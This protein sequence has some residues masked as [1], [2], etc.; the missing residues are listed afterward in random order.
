[1]NAIRIYS[2]NAA[3][4]KFVVLKTNRNKRFRYHEFFVEGVRSINEAIRNNWHIVSLLYTTEKPLSGWAG[5]M[6]EQVA[7]DVNYELTARLMS[8]LSGKD[9]TSELMAVVRMRDDSTEP[10]RFSENPVIALFDRP[11]NKG[12]LGTVIRSCD[13][14]GVEELIITS[15]SVDLYDPDVIASAM[16]SFFRVPVVRASNNKQVTG[17][18]EAMKDRYPKF[19]VIGTTAH[20]QSP[21]DALDLTGPVLFMIG[22]ETEGLCQSLRDCCDVLATIPMS[23][24][25]SASSLN[26][27]CAATVMF[28]ETARQRKLF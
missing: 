20:E 18:I 19:Q 16:G 23:G 25:S 11:S 7:S 24:S 12:N 10:V 27:G 26:A 6:L 9:D 14:L 28:Y 8:E 17:F 21:I 5:N 2:S 3:F 15:H 22:N 4:Q 1:M 13:A